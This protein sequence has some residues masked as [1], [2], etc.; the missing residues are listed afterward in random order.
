MLEKK[1]KSWN[2]GIKGFC[3][4]A[5]SNIYGF[6]SKYVDI[7]GGRRKHVTLGETRSWAVNSD[8]EFVFKIKDLHRTPL[9]FRTGFLAGGLLI[10]KYR[11]FLACCDNN[12]RTTKTAEM[13]C[14]LNVWQTTN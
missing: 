11:L 6:Y 1:L 9:E 3:P 13:S 4:T 8:N 2:M 7:C 12:K 10:W 5:L 14:V